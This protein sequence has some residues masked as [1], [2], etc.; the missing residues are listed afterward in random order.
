[1]TFLFHKN[2]PRLSAVLACLMVAALAA[3]VY[4]STIFQ[5]QFNTDREG[6]APGFGANVGTGAVWRSSGGNPGGY[7][8]ADDRGS[9]GAFTWWYTASSGDGSGFLGNDTA[10]YGGSLSYDARLFNPSGSYY[11]TTNDYDVRLLSNYNGGTVLAYFGGFQPTTSW[12][13]FTVP[14]LAS[15]GWQKFIGSNAYTPATEAELIGVLGNVQQM[16]IRGNYLSGED[17]SG[18]D[19]VTLASAVPEPGTVCLLS[20]MIGGLLAYRSCFRARVVGKI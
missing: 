20:A 16:D 12:A 7:L 3:P 9:L 10:A 5:S 8:G 15:G 14:L 19:N 18:L 17:G 6:F 1:M 13:T 4:A 11:Q 2:Y